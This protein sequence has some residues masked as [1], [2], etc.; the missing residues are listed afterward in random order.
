M[1]RFYA[2]SFVSGIAGLTLLAICVCAV[3]FGGDESSNT[4]PVTPP[5][6]R[7]VPEFDADKTV[8]AGQLRIVPTDRRDADSPPLGIK[9]PVTAG[10]PAGTKIVRRFFNDVTQSWCLVVTHPNYLKTPANRAVPV[11]TLVAKAGE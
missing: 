6:V 1:N 10:T 8:A 5:I 4:P 3:T 7:D 2:F 9:L 11:M